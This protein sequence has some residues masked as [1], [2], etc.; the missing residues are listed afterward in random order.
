MRKITFLLSLLVSVWATAQVT[1]P[2]VSTD[3]EKHYY[4]FI[5]ADNDDVRITTNGFGFQGTLEEASTLFTFE[6]AGDRKSVV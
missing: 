4:K 2:E 6:D 3:A 5:S 1:V